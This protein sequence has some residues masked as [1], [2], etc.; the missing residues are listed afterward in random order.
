MRLNTDERRLGERLLRRFRYQLIRPHENRF[1]NAAITE[2]YSQG[3]TGV[4]GRTSERSRMGG[5]MADALPN[6][7]FQA[8]QDVD[9]L[10]FLFLQS[11]WFGLQASRLIPFARL[12]DPMFASADHLLEQD[13][14]ERCG[15]WSCRKIAKPAAA[16]TD[17]RNQWRLALRLGVVQPDRLGTW[18]EIRF[19]I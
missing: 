18:S 19:Q 1:S 7:Y 5:V 15:T 8:G 14:S 12:S 4:D 16:S 13:A 9:H 2:E 17:L 11:P 10:L 3:E 6:P